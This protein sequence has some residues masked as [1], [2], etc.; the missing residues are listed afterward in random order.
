MFL[1][2]KVLATQQL[3]RSLIRDGV[4]LQDA[5]TQAMTEIGLAD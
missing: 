1:D 2:L 3:M 5:E 4:D